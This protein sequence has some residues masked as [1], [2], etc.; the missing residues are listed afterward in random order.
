MVN[1]AKDGSLDI[2]RQPAVWRYR[3]YF[4]KSNASETLRVMRSV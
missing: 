3:S 2:E 4:F 1:V